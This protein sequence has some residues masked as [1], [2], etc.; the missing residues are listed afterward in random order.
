MLTGFQGTA[1][2]HVRGGPIPRDVSMATDST[3]GAAACHLCGAPGTIP[4]AAYPSLPR[5]T[6]DCKPW[7]PGG[8]LVACPGCGCVQ[9]VIDPAWRDEAGRVYADYTLYYQAGGMEQAVFDPASGAAAPRSEQV[10]RRIRE[11]HHLPETGRM[12]DVGCGNGAFLRAFSRLIPGWH[13]F[14][15]E[16]SDRT[17]ETVAQ[18]PGFET[19]YTCPIAEVPGRFDLVSIIH[20]LEHIPDPRPFLADVREKLTEGGTLVIQVP[21][22]AQ[23]PFD[24]MIVDHSTHF[25]PETLG[26]LVRSCGFGDVVVTTDWV[27][28]EISLI[29][30][31]SGVPAREG[32]A[33][34]ADAAR[35]AERSLDWL[36]NVLAQARELAAGGRFG[37]FGTSIASMWLLGDLGDRVEFFVEEDPHRVGRTLLGRPVYRP[38]DVP[39]DAHVLVALAPHVAESVCRRLADCE[40]T[41]HPPAGATSHA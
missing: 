12:I 29:A 6:S 17:R 41:F 35:S 7:P 27:P 15:T 14:G 20:V 30:H 4:L 31:P 3:G 33:P 28:K 16:Q 23:N 38:G 13:L 22:A 37:L 40:A 9:K 32:L 26:A 2:A 19:L 1:S 24:L 25:T 5:V 11:L 39:R 36:G 21:N 34:E 8:Q 18:I 10:I